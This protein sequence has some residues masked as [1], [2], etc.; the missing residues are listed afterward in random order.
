MHGT[1]VYCLENLSS[2]CGLSS[3]SAFQGEQYNTASII[4]LETWQWTELT[5]MSEARKGHACGR[6]GT[7]IV[8]TGGGNKQDTSE[9]FSL[10]TGTWRQGPPVPGG[11]W[12]YAASSAYV[13]TANSF[14]ILG[15]YTEHGD[16]NIYEF[17]PASSAW[18]TS[19]LTL[20]MERSRHVAFNI[21]RE[22]CQARDENQL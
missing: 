3:L 10:L 8:V 21:P 9:I 20:Q 22:F 14:R 5:P 17:D 19:D 7:D 11:D 16:R 1:L 4:N 12:L 15:G 2:I 13:Q 6:A 18:V